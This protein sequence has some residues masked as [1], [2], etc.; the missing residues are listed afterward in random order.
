M[1]FKN[2]LKKVLLLVVFSLFL[3]FQAPVNAVFAADLTDDIRTLP[4]N[5]AGDTKTYSIQEIAQGERLFNVVCATCHVRGTTKTNP[6]VGLSL[7][8][9]E[10]AVPARD[11]IEALIDYMKNPTTYDGEFEL[12]EF[13]PS[14]RSADIFP[15]MR[16]LTESDLDQIA[17]YLL[18]QPRVQGA[19]WGGG[20][21]TY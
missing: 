10:G 3:F 20:K 1:F 6:N 18:L 13:H 2:F 4:L 14:I 19:R 15:K 12:Y 8:E 9:L 7:E 5:E 17:G 16:N 11:N 21:Y